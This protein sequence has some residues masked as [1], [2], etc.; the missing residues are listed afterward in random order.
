MLTSKVRTDLGRSLRFREKNRLVKLF[1]TDNKV[2]ARTEYQSLY[3]VTQNALPTF[4]SL[5]Y[6]GPITNPTARSVI[7]TIDADVARRHCL[8]PVCP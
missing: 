2:S 3:L 5:T 8:M 7:R 4:L 1:V 6:D